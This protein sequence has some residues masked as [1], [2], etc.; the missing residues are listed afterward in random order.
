MRSLNLVVLSLG[1]FAAGFRFTGVPSSATAG[2]STSATLIRDNSDPTAF[3]LL[4]RLNSHFTPTE[5]GSFII[6]V[7]SDLE[8]ISATEKPANIYA[9]SSSITVAVDDKVS[10]PPPPTPITSSE[11][12]SSPQNTNT[13]TTS[14]SAT[15]ATT[16][17]NSFPIEDP[18]IGNPSGTLTSATRDSSVV[19]TSPSISTSGVSVDG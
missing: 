12:V 13:A 16:T 2:Q 5:A 9:S 18:S 4:L 11:N 8:P 10:V 19:T 1:T 15:A 7:I 17:N 6:E 14:F 3:S